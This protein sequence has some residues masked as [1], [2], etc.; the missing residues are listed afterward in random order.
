MAPVDEDYT[1]FTHLLG[2]PNPATNG[3]LWAGHDSQP[4]SGHYPTTA[5]QPG[6]VILD[7]HPLTI[8]LDAPAGDYQLEVGLY[9]L[10]NMSRLP[11][12]DGHGNPLPDDAAILGTLEI[13]D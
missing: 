1:V 12:V 4:D 2:D 5:W 6:Q 7:R 3:P 9:L 11:A 13:R 8:P 10:A